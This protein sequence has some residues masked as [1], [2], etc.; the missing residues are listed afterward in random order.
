MQ[1]VQGW[2]VAK[3]LQ[4]VAELGIADLLADSAKTSEELARA[5][6]TNPSALFRLLRALA[7]R[8]VFRQNESGLFENTALSEPLRSDSP[9]SVRDYLIY[10]PNDGNVR[11]WMR[12]MSVLQTGEPSFAEANGCELW[13]YFQQH[14]DLGERFNRAM[15]TL[16][17]GN[18]RMVLEAY[19][20]SP[21]KTLIDVGGGQ[22][23]LI[24]EILKAHPHL[25]GTL[26]D[27]PA[28]ADGARAHLTAQGVVDRCE[29]VA[30][31][32]FTS[33]P[34]G[35]EAYVLKNVL[36]DWSD[37]RCAVLLDRCRAAIP[38]HGKLIIVD[39]VMVPGNDSHPAKWFDLHMMV[40]LG[41]RERTEKEFR[42]LLQRV[43]F[44]LTMAK[45]LPAPIGIVEAIPR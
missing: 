5:T 31:D 27:L 22:G 19:D 1:L 6:S 44:T 30:G 38:P 23:Q 3:A 15:T 28:V 12:L 25:R 2:M 21:F 32:A 14:S 42:N 43:G 41:G 45:S 11:A 10:A 8:G 35:F 24:A 9:T 7:G 17:S 33:I 34:A 4:A 37:D 36:H 18:N 40:A 26:F 39:A 13:E 20:F 29:F 16:A